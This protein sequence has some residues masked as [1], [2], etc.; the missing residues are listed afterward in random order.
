VSARAASGQEDP[1]WGWLPPLLRPRAT[2]PDG[3][4]SLRLIETTVLV[5]VA[6]VLAIATVNDV[7]RQTGVDH[8]IGADLKTWRQYTHHDFKYVGV[9]TTLLGAATTRDVVCGNEVAGAPKT[10]PQICLVLTGPTRAGRRTVAGGWYLQPRSED[11]RSR[12]YGCFGS[13]TMGLCP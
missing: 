3:D 13:V 6:L 8:R 9:D 5:L 1:R 12:R 11:V 7:V 10:R 4:G 2:E